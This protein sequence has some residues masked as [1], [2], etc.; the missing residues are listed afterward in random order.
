MGNY[1]ILYAILG[2]FSETDIKNSFWY[3]SICENSSPFYQRML[4]IKY[5]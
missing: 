3:Q 2:G 5:G 4:C 1:Q